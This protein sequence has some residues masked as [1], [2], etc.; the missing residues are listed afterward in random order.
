[1]TMHTKLRYKMLMHELNQ[2][3]RK[4]DPIGLIAMGAPEDE[5]EAEV[6]TIAPRLRTAQSA[7][8]TTRIVYE[9]F[10]HWFGEES[11]TGPESSYAA[12]GEAIWQLTRKYFG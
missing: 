2:V 12:L 7:Q 5:Y 1:M 9:E 10:V 4:H 8:E 3:V 11:T 6:G